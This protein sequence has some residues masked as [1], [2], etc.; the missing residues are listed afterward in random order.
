MPTATAQL[1]E[2]FSV[3]SSVSDVRTGH[4]S[5]LFA[6][7]WRQQAFIWFRMTYNRS[8][9]FST[10]DFEM[11]EKKF[12]Q[13][14]ISDSQASRRSTRRKSSRRWGERWRSRPST[15]SRATPGP[16]SS[17]RSSPH[18]RTCVT[19]C[20]GRGHGRSSVKYR[21]WTFGLALELKARPGFH[22]FRTLCFVPVQLVAD[23]LSTC[24]VHRESEQCVTVNNKLSGHWV[25]PGISCRWFCNNYYIVF[26]WGTFISVTNTDP[27]Q[28]LACGLIAERCVCASDLRHLL[29]S[30]PSVKPIR[31]T[32][33]SRKAASVWYRSSFGSSP[34]E[35][36]TNASKSLLQT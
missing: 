20:S 14:A 16:G 8:W 15:W 25:H 32:T 33:I 35:F 27:Q 6:R 36:R 21:V 26:E 10:H 7:C 4:F 2:V 9:I 12:P 29:E 3:Q 17:A 18:T 11:S 19:G 13:P 1:L 24:T 31:S 30:S 28:C 23:S 34:A 22:A 5:I